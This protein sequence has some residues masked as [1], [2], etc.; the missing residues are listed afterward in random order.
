MRLNYSGRAPRWFYKRANRS[1]TLN[2]AIADQLA[3]DGVAMPRL[4]SSAAAARVDKL[5]SSEN[6]GCNASARSIA[7]P[8][9]LWRGQRCPA[10]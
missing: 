4:S 5:A 6:T 3:P 7:A 2:T 10:P 8:G 1:R 9:W